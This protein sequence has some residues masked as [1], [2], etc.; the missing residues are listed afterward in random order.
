[1]DNDIS[2]RIR[3]M[4]HDLPKPY[5]SLINDTI[6]TANKHGIAVTITS[7][8]SLQTQGSKRCNGYF[9]ASDETSAGELAVATGKKS[10]NTWISTFAHESS[11]MDQWI[12]QCSAWKNGSKYDFDYSEILQMWIDHIVELNP[13]Q[14]AKIITGVR[15]LELDCERRAVKKMKVYGLPVDIKE[16]IQKANAYVYFYTIMGL[17][18]KWYKIGQEPYVVDGVWGNMP[19]HFNNDYSKISPSLKKVFNKIL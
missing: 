10:L 7:D 13:N 4:I 17:K 19:T 8:E 14:K 5:K 16:Y 12:A 18:R 1:M 11:H 3:A 15:N 2:L 6:I 9:I